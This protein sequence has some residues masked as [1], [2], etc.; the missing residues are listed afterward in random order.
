MVTTKRPENC[1]P[2]EWVKLSKSD[3]CN[4]C[5]V[6]R[7]HEWETDHHDRWCK[8]CDEV[9][10]FDEGNWWPVPHSGERKCEG[11]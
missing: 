3:R 10:W 11:K 1:K 6:W 2:H 5:G 7:W 8:H 9:E 4:V